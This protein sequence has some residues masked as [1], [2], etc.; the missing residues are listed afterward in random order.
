MLD[1]RYTNQII[2]GKV[3]TERNNY[4]AKYFKLNGDL[5]ST[6]GYDGYSLIMADS[7]CVLRT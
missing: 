3:Y 5:L 2:S 4:V 6:V 7:F 1:I